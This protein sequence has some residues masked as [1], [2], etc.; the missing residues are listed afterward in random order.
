MYFLGGQ[1]EIKLSKLSKIIS[2]VSLAFCSNTLADLS[3]LDSSIPAYMIDTTGFDTGNKTSILPNKYLLQPLQKGNQNYGV[4]ILTSKKNHTSSSNSNSI[5]HSF[6]FG[7]AADNIQQNL[8]QDSKEMDQ[9]IDEVIRPVYPFLTKYIYNGEVYLINS[10]YL[11]DNNISAV[12]FGREEGWGLSFDFSGK[13]TLKLGTI[14]TYGLSLDYNFGRS[15]LRKTYGYNLAEGINQ[16]GINIE[17]LAKSLND[18]IDLENGSKLL[19][20]YSREYAYN[21]SSKPIEKNNSLFKA[22]FLINFDRDHR[23]QNHL[24]V[25]IPSNIKSEHFKKRNLE[26]LENLDEE[27][28]WRKKI[29]TDMNRVVDNLD[30]QIFIQDLCD[31]VADVFEL[32]NELRPECYVSASPVPNASS[33][34]GGK[35]M[36]T[37]GIIGILEDMDSLLSAVGHEIAH[38]VARHVTKR[39]GIFNSINLGLNAIIITQN[40][41]AL[42]GGNK[43]FSKIPLLKQVFDSWYFNTVGS[44]MYSSLALEVAMKIPLMGLMM[45]SREHEMEADTLGQEAAY[46]AGAKT[47]NMAKGWQNFQDFKVRIGADN[48][49]LYGRLTSSHPESLD[50]KKEILN[51]AK[52]YPV[53]SEFYNTQNR[54][55]SFYYLIYSNYHNQF[56]KL[57]DKYVHQLNNKKRSNKKQYDY[58]INSIIRSHTNCISH[59][60][61]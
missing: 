26:L 24:R 22:D 51:R 19:Q 33:Y 46:L 58:H 48:K 39:M 9:Y 21:N 10:K 29:N 42:Q 34:P 27:I 8:S 35:L 2:I 31:H 20:L 43:P 16:L 40:L 3:F 18:P 41:W 1:R 47:E 49:S 38:Y 37:A 5:S 4:K 52:N 50:R 13:K 25:Q 45:Y 55:D 17:N 12:S 30:L 61:G 56:K 54:M 36:F 32:P 53:G 60:F 11:I 59:I 44:S 14:S 15:D 7:K 6:A 28:Q 23:H 57:I